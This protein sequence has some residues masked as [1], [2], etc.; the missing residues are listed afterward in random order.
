MIVGGG[1]AGLSAAA[2]LG[3]VGF[4][5]E[6]HEARPF[7]GGRATSF[8]VHPADENSERIDN[9]QHVLL[10]CCTNLLDFYR[11]CGV[12]EAIEFHKRLYFVQPGGEVDVLE[13]GLLPAPLHLTGSL[14]RFRALGASDKWS[15]VRGLLAI[16]RERF[17]DDLDQITMGEWLASKGVSPRSVERFWRPILVSA[18]NEEPARASA[19]PAFQVF[20]QGLMGRHDSYE[21]GVPRVPLADLY[22]AAIE[23]KLG[24]GVHIH[25]RSSVRTVDPTSRQADYYIS[26]VPFEKVPELLPNL[27]LR[28]ERFEHSP[29]TGIHLWYDRAITSLPHAVLLDR[30]LQ[31]IFRKSENCFQAVVSASRSLLSMSKSEIV[32]L[33]CRE[34]QEFFPEARR[35]RLLR[36]HVIKEARATYAA[37]PGL[38]SLRPPPATKYPNVFLAGDWTDTG[39]PATMEGA[40][41]SGY[42]AAEAVA[43]A[44]GLPASFLR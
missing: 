19:L 33:A 34:L 35:A 41:R 30:T 5:V 12:E 29:I 31:W 20:W 16:R 9:C 44:A 42:L 21:M 8:P 37:V 4:E 23:K 28:L 6:L 25:L 17:R 27:G 24:A 11:R 43:R 40:V 14:L 36:S 39:W 10:R 13:R 32:E 3:S 2:A 1:L 7:L 15:I 22:S 38:N 26:A 18:L